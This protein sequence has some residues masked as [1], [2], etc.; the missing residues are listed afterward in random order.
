MRRAVLISN[1]VAS[2]VTPAVETAVLH[3][4]RGHAE[5]ELVRTERP[6]HARDLARAAADDGYDAV[7]VLAGDGTANEVLN[8]VGVRVAIGLLPA[9][10]TS[11]SRSPLPAARAST[12]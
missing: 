8:G 12:R 6:L 5:V 4:L 3:A 9:G 10:G 7:L 2:G 11:A 1:P